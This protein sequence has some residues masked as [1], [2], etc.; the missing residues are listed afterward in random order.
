MRQYIVL[1]HTPWSSSP[2]RTQQLVTRLGDAQVLFF[3]PAAGP[4]DQA[5]KEGGRLVR[6]DVTAFTLPPEGRLSDRHPLFRRRSLRKQAA[7]IERQL[8]RHKFREP[9]LW[10]TSPE[11]LPFL[12]YF[13][14]RGLVYDCDRFWPPELDDQES[15][16]A[17]NADVI[18]A[19]SPLLRERLAPCSSNVALLPNGV[20]YPMY[21]RGNEELP[22]DLARLMKPILGWAGAIDRRLDLSPVQAIADRHPEWTVALLGPIEDCP[23]VRRLATHSNVVFLG[24]RPAVDLPDYLAQFQVLLNLRRQEELESDVIPGRIYEYLSTGRPIVSLLLPEEVEEFPDVIYGAHSP[25]EFVDLCRRAL[26][27]DPTWVA[28]RRRDYGAAAAWS[29][30]AEEVRRI[31]SSISM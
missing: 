16:L 28:P 8:A 22:A 10:V 25:E 26:E 3:Q 31:L 4:E 5:W 12:D 1:S 11:H 17:V 18:F 29:R 24:P 13:A 27:E 2:T 7:Y 23:A 30:R 21:C 9:I 6:P 15:E 14:Y 20:N 19:A